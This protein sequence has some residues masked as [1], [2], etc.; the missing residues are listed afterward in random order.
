MANRVDAAIIGGGAA[1]LAA[2][3]RL[4]RAGVDVLALE[5]RDRIGGRA[6]T[7]MAGGFPVDL[8]CGW[9]HSADINPFSRIAQDLGVAIDRTP[10]HWTRQAAAPNFPSADQKSFRQALA[11]LESRIEAAAALGRDQPVS[12]LMDANDRW[13]PLL[14]AFSAYYNGAEFDQI[15][16]MDYAAYRDTEINWRA[17]DGYGALIARFGAEAPVALECPVRRVDHRGRLARLETPRGALEARVVIVTAPTPLIADG[18]IAFTPDI[19]A[20]REAAAGLPLG[21]ADKVFFGVDRAEDLPVD[22]HLF[23]APSRTQTGSYHLRPFGRPIIEVF[24][25]GRHARELEA[26]GEGA[27]VAFAIEELT[28]I[29]GS[30]IRARLTPLAATAWATDPWSLGAYSHATPGCAGARAALGPAVKERIIFAGEA[31]S[32]DFFS[33]AHGAALSGVAAADRALALLGDS[34]ATPLERGSREFPGVR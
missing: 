15:S 26:E 19:P 34:R 2:A 27:S 22:S 12:Q 25:G 6:H 4:A 21:L 3:V 1:G 24:L 28:Q 18:A 8:G 20:V 29:L 23:G 32:P 33:T 9:L 7:V 14:N 11:A 5:A 16:T 10:P 17:P 30:D 13:F 31:T